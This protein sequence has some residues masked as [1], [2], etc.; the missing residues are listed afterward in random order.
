MKIAL[1]LARNIQPLDGLKSRTAHGLVAQRKSTTLSM[2]RL[3]CQDPS[4]SQLWVVMCYNRNMRTFTCNQCSTKVIVVSR[5]D[6]R[7]KFCSK[8]CSAT[9]NNL[10][11]ERKWSSVQCLNCLK[12]GNNYGGKSKFC[13]L[14]CSSEY[15]KKQFIDDWLSGRESG[16]QKNG[17]LKG[18][19]RRYLLS[20]ANYSCSI[21]GWDKVNPATNKS[22]LEIDHI[23]GDAFNNNIENLRVLCPNCHSLTPTYKALNTS[24]RVNRPTKI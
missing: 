2:W 22:T 20:V 12:S 21:C 19:I 24:T 8:S 10:N 13:S 11:R 4:R 15:R 14:K 17:G 3:R 16:S 1:L 23:D 5:K 7:T 18:A 9:F 6:S